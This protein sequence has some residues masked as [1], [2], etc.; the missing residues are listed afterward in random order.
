[1]SKPNLFI[2]GAPKCATTSLHSYLATHPD[3]VMSNPKEPAFFGADLRFSNCPSLQDYLKMFRASPGISVRGEATAFY[4]FSRTAA[5]EIHDFNPE[6]KII[7]LLRNPVD[8]MY[9]HYLHAVRAGHE[10]LSFEKALSR[11][12]DRIEEAERIAQQRNA[13]IFIEGFARYRAVASYSSQVTR[14]IDTFARDNIL[15]LVFEEFID[16][17]PNYYQRVLLFLGLDTRN[18][19]EQFNGENTQGEIR[20]HLL[21]RW[22]LDPPPGIPATIELLAG[23][24]RK[25]ALFRWLSRLS[26]RRRKMPELA[27]KLRNQLLCEFSTEVDAVE[28]ILGRELPEWRQ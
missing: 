5:Q 14:Y 21:K 23:K 4:L 19:P 6:S 16:E 26:E 1:M 8:Q 18:V 20:S 2:V 22:L 10:T 25:A 12:G 3:V 15:I 11:E 7:I 28:R 27:P 17:T 13:G 24:E 9:S